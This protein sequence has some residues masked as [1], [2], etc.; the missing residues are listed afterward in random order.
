MKVQQE[1][2]ASGGM[3]DPLLRKSRL[4]FMFLYVM[5]SVYK[6]RIYKEDTASQNLKFPP[7]VY[8][9]L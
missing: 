3:T 6:T 1:T 4:S 5:Q 7:A 2:S 8:I 9:F